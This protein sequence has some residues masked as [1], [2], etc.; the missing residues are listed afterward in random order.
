MTITTDH[1]VTTTDTETTA[2]MAALT[3]EQIDPT[4]LLVDVNVRS[5]LRLNKAFLASI[6]DHGVLVPIT[7]TRDVD[8]LRVRTGHRRVAAA[9]ALEL[10]AIPVVVVARGDDEAARII[11]QMAEN[12]HRTEV[13]AGERIAATNQLALLGVSA[14]QI[15][16]KMHRPR[17]EVDAALAVGDS[18]FG[19]QVATAHTLQVAAWTMEFDGDDNAVR[20]ILDAAKRGGE[21]AARHVVE[22]ERQD[23]DRKAAVAEVAATLRADNPGVVVLDDRPGYD[24]DAAATIDR[25]TGV[26]PKNHQTCPHRALLVQRS[27]RDTGAN[28]MVASN[29]IAVEVSEWCLDWRTAGHTHQYLSATKATGKASSSD[30]AAN[31]KAKAEAEAASAERRRVLAGNRDWEAASVVRKEWVNGLLARKTLPKDATTV[32]AQAAHVTSLAFGYTERKT[33]YAAA[34]DA[35]RALLG[36][37]LTT[38]E[39]AT[40]RKDWRNHKQAKDST[41]VLLTALIAWGYTP[42]PVE[43]AAAGIKAYVAL[44][45]Q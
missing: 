40:D 33:T 43:E 21:G 11:E 16:K 34:A 6:R 23:R 38:L 31:A 14:A 35:T 13:T 27:Y 32:I 18:E 8:G 24:N 37:A 44:P 26:G 1:P 29:G 30:K 41:R 36:L 2:S 20:M 42:A 10:P 19:V 25:L 5:D 15:A 28:A 9:V 4:T 45:K 7:A 39:A 12:D 22:R 3:V 17:K